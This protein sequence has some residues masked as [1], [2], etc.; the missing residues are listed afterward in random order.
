MVVPEKGETGGPGVCLFN[1]K[2]HTNSKPS[3]KRCKGR[4]HCNALL[5]FKKMAFFRLPKFKIVQSQFLKSV[6][7]AIFTWVLGVMLEC[8]VSPPNAIQNGHI[9]GGLCDAQWR[10]SV[11]LLI[12]R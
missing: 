8:W 6:N 1:F 2:I 12:H 5:F 3:C 11:V 7:L 4:G 10:Y 9:S